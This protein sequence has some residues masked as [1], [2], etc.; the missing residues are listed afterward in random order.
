MNENEQM[1]AIFVAFFVK[2]C[3][4][5]YWLILYNI[6]HLFLRDPPSFIYIR[7]YAHI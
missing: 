2:A 4:A 1:N 3:K 5:K 6:P 7:I